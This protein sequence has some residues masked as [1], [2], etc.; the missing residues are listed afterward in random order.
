MRKPKAGDILRGLPLSVAC[1]VLLTAFTAYS[2]EQ[3][4]NHLSTLTVQ[5]TAN[6]TTLVVEGSAPPTFT[7]FKLTNPTRLFVDISNADISKIEGPIEVE[8]G[9]IS[10]ITPASIHR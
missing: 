8:N 5:E 6:A 2:Q 4:T 3:E 1:L 9:V 7:V 10:Q